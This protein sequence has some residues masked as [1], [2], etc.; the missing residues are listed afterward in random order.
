MAKTVLIVD[1]DPDVHD[2]LELRLSTFGFDMVHAM[3]GKEGCIKAEELKPDLIFLDV[4]MPAMSGVEVLKLL[5]GQAPDDV[6]KIPVVMLTSHEHL[7][8]DC[9]K[10]GASAY[11]TK[12]FDL[13]ALKEIVESLV[14]EKS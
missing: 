8:D 4:T 14:S 6:K 9:L 10:L 2:V 12:P 5:K 13:F 1:D 7:Q 3:N 11:M